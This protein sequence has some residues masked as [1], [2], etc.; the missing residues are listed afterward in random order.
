M[1]PNLK[2]FSVDLKGYGYNLNE[3][4]AT[5]FSDFN[6]IRIN[7]MSPNM[8]KFITINEKDQIEYIKKYSNNIESKDK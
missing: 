3:K 8:L 4:L 6:F 2:I 5:Y 1:N 7:G